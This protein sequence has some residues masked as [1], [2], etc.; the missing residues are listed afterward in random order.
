MAQPEVV[1]GSMRLVRAVADDLTSV[2]SVEELAEAW[3]RATELAEAAAQG[4]GMETEA[5][6]DLELVAGAAFA[7][8][9][10]E[11]AVEAG[12]RETSRRIEEARTA[13]REWV[14]LEEAGVAEAPFP[15]P[16]RRLEMRLADG[17]GLLLTAELDPDSGGIVHAIEGLQL[18]PSSGDATGSGEP[19]RR[20]LAD[21]GEWRRAAEDL[22]QSPLG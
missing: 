3:G 2:R 21:P 5:A 16:Y 12:R 10:R 20:E 19:A 6:A 18:D 14:V 8:R 9:Y 1:A 15:Q 13:G 22:R 4:L 7:L 11:L 17:F